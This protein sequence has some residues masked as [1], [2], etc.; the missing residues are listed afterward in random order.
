MRPSLPEPTP[1]ARA[2]SAAL[3]ALIAE[4]IAAAG[5]WI[6][7]ARYMELALYAPG[8][9]Y[10]SGGARKFGAA[11]DFI[12]A[13]ELTPLF[14]QTVAAQALQIMAGSALQILEVGAGSGVMAAELLRELGRR[15]DLPE[16][17][18]IL[19]LSGELRARQ[20][21]TLEQRVPHLL[22]RVTW[23]D[24]LPHRFSGLALGNEVLDAMPVGLVEW[25]DTQGAA[26]GATEIL[27]RGVALGAQGDFVWAER[28]AQG[29]LL[30]AAQGLSIAAPYV[31]EIGLAAA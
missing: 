29:A 28:P 11:G 22:E 1:D 18:L 27:E 14:A 6:P 20:Q 8:L 17:Y 24:T 13:P 30:Q 23:I 19:E 21:A 9:G 12:T 5:G 31:S 4:E 7:F 2:A 3:C 25:R 26:T 16:R 10:Y 15:G